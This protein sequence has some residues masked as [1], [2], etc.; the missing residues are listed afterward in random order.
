MSK[1]TDILNSLYENI[2]M[3]E[4]AVKKVLP[5]VKDNALKS[6]LQREFRDYKNQCNNIA[7]QL[8]AENHKPAGAGWWTKAM[9]SAGIAFNCAKDSSSQHIAEMMIQ[10][11]NMGVIKIN[12]ALNAA[13]DASPK[14]VQ[15]A[16]NIL[17]NQQKYIDNLKTYL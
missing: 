15:E 4:S 5:K 2:S 9:S 10:G 14:V 16:K 11:T 13:T 6:E 17:E 8:K 7:A 12:K 3:G 1:E